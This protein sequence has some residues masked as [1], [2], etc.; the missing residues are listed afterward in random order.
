MAELLEQI[1]QLPREERLHLL[2]E[3][4]ASVQEDAG[5]SPLSESERQLLVQR[6]HESAKNPLQ[7]GTWAQL[8]ARL[9]NNE[10]SLEVNSS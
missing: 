9:E 1:R 10:P 6:M 5:E 4:C 3:I 2:E 8:R 7:G